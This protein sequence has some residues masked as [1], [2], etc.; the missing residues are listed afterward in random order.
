MSDGTLDIVF[1]FNTREAI[2]EAREI[3]KNIKTIGTTASKVNSEAKIQEGLLQ[4]LGRAADLYKKGMLEATRVENI[5]KY[6]QKLEVVNAEML[7][8]TKPNIGGSAG[9]W[10]GLQNSI[11]QLSRELPAFTYSAQTGF[12]AIS[13]NIPILVDELNRAK[14][15]NAALNAEGQKGV[16]VWKQLIGSVFS[17]GT[18]LSLGVTLLTVYGKEIGTFLTR[19]F[20]GKQAAD[21]FKISVDYLNEAI[22]STEFLKAVKDVN[23]LRSNIELA[24]KG[25]LDKKTVVEQYNESLG[26]SMGTVK[27]F[28]ELQQREIDTSPAYLKMM[29]NK[30]AAMLIMEEAANDLATAEKKRFEY[31]QKTSGKF[32]FNG[33]TIDLTKLGIADSKNPEVQAEINRYRQ[34]RQIVEQVKNAGLAQEIRDDERRADQKN[35]IAAK[36]NE[37]AAKIAKENG[38]NFL[39]FDPKK[40]PSNGADVSKIFN[41]MADASKDFYN[42]IEDLDKEYARKSMESDEAELQALKDKF[43]KVRRE[44]EEENKKIETYNKNNSGKKGFQQVKTIDMAKLAP[45]EQRAEEDVRY[46]QST[47][48]LKKEIEAQKAIFEEYEEYKG[49]LG[50]DKADTEFKERLKGFKTYVEYLKSIAENESEAFKAVEGKTATAGQ[51]ER[52]KMVKNEQKESEA[53]ERRKQTDLMALLITY[54]QQRK[55]LVRKFEEQR[56]GLIAKASA[57]E[58]AAF[59]R[60]HVEELNQLDDANI[61]QL[62]AYKNLFDGIERLT[63][64]EARKVIQN[65]EALLATGVDISPEL[66]KKVREALKD[67]TKSL[68]D[69]LPER[70]MQLSSSFSKMGQEIGEV[71]QGLGQMLTFVGEVLSSSVQIGQN[72]TALSK[73]LDNYNAWKTEKNSGS[74]KGGVAGVLG[75]ISA[76]AGVAGPIGGIVSAVAGVASGVFKFFGAA[77]ESARQAEKQLREYQQKI[78]EG[79]LEYG[80]LIRERARGQKEINDM[81]L[82]ELATQKE[83]LKTQ[84]ETAKVRD[85]TYKKVV[86]K[87]FLGR[88]IIKDFNKQEILSDYEYVLQKILNEGTEVTGQR[89]EKY[90]GFLGVGKKTRL[91][92]ITASLAGKTYDDLE[93]LYTE[94]K[95]NDAT[96]AMFENLQ[97]AKKEVDDINELM[98]EI[99]EQVMDKMTNSLRASTLSDSIIQG[100]KD[101]KRAVIDWSEDINGIVQD[102]LLS[103][104]KATVL[105][106]PLM[107]LVKKFREDSKDGLSDDEIN[108]FKEGYNQAVQNGLDALKEIEKITGKVGSDNASSSIKSEGIARISEQTGTELTGLYRVNVDINKQQLK[109]FDKSLEFHLKTNDLLLQQLK[110]QAAIEKN[111]ADTVGRLDAALTELKQIS[112]N[113]SQ[114]SN[115]AYYGA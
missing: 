91:V 21:D 44:I 46:K 47:N 112:R 85:L 24:K 79:E 1:E 88:D 53:A 77:K 103:A 10:N 29:L 107:E 36:I 48:S 71:N 3:E 104:M 39:N 60:K 40:T 25:F 66:L 7:K 87:D 96:K 84:L 50:Q 14:A 2:S 41:Q 35:K 89:K 86:G 8:L 22:K 31:E 9:Q 58:L 33:K 56:A 37:K 99:D 95:M 110:Y 108:K 38:L 69:R 34:G 113:T 73:G 32:D 62:N 61:Q 20:K 45:I 26:R 23:E 68:D 101:G 4:R 17:W 93:K 72:F 80:R 76:I 19:L 6:R 109:S 78:I 83:L 57:D 59:D 97:K 111:T 114:Q 92:D 12:M 43:A 15:A 30:T 74:T 18:A 70:V 115:R 49:K 106:E 102:A 11:N 63:D 5:E 81:S 16:P 54:D 98:K 67:A 64:S 75:G 13:N 51:D 90:G 28:Q 100:L 94:G 55:E 82:A 105:E 52:V 42:K 65:M 27:S